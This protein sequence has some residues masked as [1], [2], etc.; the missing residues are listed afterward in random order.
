MSLLSSL[1]VC[2]RRI[3]HATSNLTVFCYVFRCSSRVA[4]DDGAAAAGADADGAD[5]DDDDG[6]DSD[7]DE[8]R[9]ISEAYLGKNTP[10]KERKR[11]KRQSSEAWNFIARLRDVPAAM[12]DAGYSEAQIKV[13]MGGPGK[14]G[15]V[16]HVCTACFELLTIGYDT[17]ARAVRSRRPLAP[18]ARAPC[19]RR[20][21]ALTARPV[22]SARPVRSRRPRRSTG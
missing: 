13:A 11:A 6:L 17:K 15:K 22:L 4:Q 10:N 18:P 20:P 5:D 2:F 8:L 12:R 16:T 9:K 1:P 21:L 7:T 3:H 19:S 14:R